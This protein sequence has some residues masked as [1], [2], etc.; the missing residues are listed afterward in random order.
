P[1]KRPMDNVA[2]GWERPQED[3]FALCSLGLPTPYRTWAFPRRGPVDA[4]WLTLEGVDADRLADWKRRLDQFV[5][6]VTL[7]RPGRRVVLKSPP[8]TARVRT[9]LEVFPDARFVHIVRDPSA[10]FPSTVRLWKSLSDVQTLQWTAKRHDWI[11]EEV[12]ANLVRMYEAYERD[13]DLI[14]DGR[15]A[16]LRYEDLVADPMGELRR[17]Y[18]DLDLGDFAAAEPGVSRYLAAERDYRTNRFEV[19]DDVRG[20]VAERWGAYAERWGY[21][22]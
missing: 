4:D 13:R 3:E 2:T 7:R 1:K 14:P 12:L 18:N 9:L 19:P 16:E 11:E 22:A 17:V 15:L 21:A 8:H 5:R 20:R 6:A 10:L